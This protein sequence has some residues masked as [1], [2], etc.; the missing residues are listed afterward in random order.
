M[1][2]S[3]ENNTENNTENSLEYEI[4]NTKDILVIPDRT[5]ALVYTV[6][7]LAIMILCPLIL[8]VVHHSVGLFGWVLS[9]TGLILAFLGLCGFVAISVEKEKYSKKA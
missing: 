1:G 4:V 8:F 9:L 6:A 2:N 3:T 5:L 7:G